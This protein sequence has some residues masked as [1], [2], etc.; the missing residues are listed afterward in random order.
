MFTTLAHSPVTPAFL[1]AVIVPLPDV[2]S[3]VVGVAA[4]FVV[5]AV[6]VLDLEVG[7]PNACFA[8]QFA[9]HALHAL[10]R[11]DDQALGA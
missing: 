11:A 5:E 8:V 2:A 10:A 6:G 7:G 4:E 9:D 3:F 1:L